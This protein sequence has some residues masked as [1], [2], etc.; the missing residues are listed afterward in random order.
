MSRRGRRSKV[1]PRSESG[2]PLHSASPGFA[3]RFR[4]LDRLR[5]AW[6]LVWL[7]AV[8]A[9]IYTFDPRLYIN[10]DNVQY[11]FLAE[12]VAAGNLW[13]SS[14]YPP[15]FPYLLV[16]IQAL[17]GMELLPQKLLV[18][19]TYILSLVF[20][21]RIVQRRWEGPFGPVVFWLGATLIPWVEY[22]HYVMS[23]VPFLLTLLI[24]WD[25]FDCLPEG[26]PKDRAALYKNGA[27]WRMSLAMLAGFYIRSAGAATV[28]G[29]LLALLLQRRPR[30]LLSLAA[31]LAVGI[32]PWAARSLLLAEGNPYLRQLLSVN[33]YVPNPE[34]LGWGTLLDRLGENGLTYFRRL[35]PRTLFPF[36]YTSTYSLAAYQKMVQPIWMAIPVL[37]A[38]TVGWV[39]LL[40]RREIAAWALLPPI[41][42]LLLWPPIWSANRFV[43]PLLPMFVLCFWEGLRLTGTARFERYGRTVRW[44]VASLFVL[45]SLVNLDNLSIERSRYETGWE[46][47]FAA[48]RWIERETEP[49]ARICDRKPE[50]TRFVAKRD[51]LNFPRTRDDEEMLQFL[52]DREIDYVLVPSIPYADILLFITPIVQRHPEHFEIIQAFQDKSKT[53]EQDR[54]AYLFR[55]HPVA[56][57]PD[58]PSG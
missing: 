36:P 38:F 10:G 20:W 28:F 25:A 30:I 56:R 26:D 53:P 57:R 4:N 43:V 42:L 6:V 17:F 23:E 18:F 3:E 55:F 2:P 5:I 15:L 58:L 44:I 33:P 49:E 22:S 11:M 46:T 21:V 16:P 31:V 24:A 29:F 1:K 40:R 47:Y 27:F 32:I 37:V 7:L 52:R 50:F 41:F 54:P 51:A 13:P 39:R 35:L 8:A 45:L 9:S 14:K 12:D 48:L 34:T 19:A